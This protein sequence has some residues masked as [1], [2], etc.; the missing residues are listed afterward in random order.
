MTAPTGPRGLTQETANRTDAATDLRTGTVTAVTARGIDVAV[1]GG[2]V[3]GAAHVDSYNPAVGD[4]VALLQLRDSWLVLGRPIGPG[5]TA[6]NITPG[7]AVGTTLLGGV[8]LAPTGAVLATSVGAQ[9]TVPKYALKFHHPRNH[10]VLLMCGV[11]WR[12]SV[13]NDELFITLWSATDNPDFAVGGTTVIQGPAVTTVAY[14][15]ITV[16]LPPSRGGKEGDY[17]MTLQR[18]LGTGTTRIDDTS[19]TNF[20]PGY[21]V[22]LD[23]A[24]ASV[25]KLV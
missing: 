4:S 25:L 5:T 20:R 15:T 17:Y 1:A 10:W 6:D 11:S 9:V 21:L 22:A 16:M 18:G 12:S 23:M 13:A 2:N 14:E 19:S 8:V 3:A 24:D 7:P